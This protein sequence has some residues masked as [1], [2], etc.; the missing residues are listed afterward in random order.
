MNR[1]EEITSFLQFVY[2]FKLQ[3]PTDFSDN[4][5][6]S[7]LCSYGLYNEEYGQKYDNKYFSYW[8]EYYR[9][10]PNIDVYKHH[11]QP[12][13]LQF[14]N[15]KKFTDY[16]YVK[17]YINT[18]K[19]KYFNVVMKIF[20]YLSKHPEIE[21]LS[22]IADTCRS[23]Q[24]VLRIKEP[25]YAKEVID[26]INN[27][28]DIVNSL[29]Y[30]NP[31]L[32]RDGLVGIAFDNALSYNS[33]MANLIYN[34]V[35]LK[36]N[37][38]EISCSDFTNY[39]SLLHDD[40]IKPRSFNELSKLVNSD[41]FLKSYNR[42]LSENDPSLNIADVINNYLYVFDQ[43][44]KLINSDNNFS[45]YSSLYDFSR[46]P[47]NNNERK[48]LI[49]EKYNM[50]YY[51]QIIDSY[52]YYAYSKYNNSEE[53]SSRLSDYAKTKI[54]NPD[55]ALRYITRD[56]GYRS[57]FLKIESNTIYYITNND[58]YTYVENILGLTKNYD[59]GSRSSVS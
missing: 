4:I 6:Y 8:I 36:T 2:K 51:K 5:I 15:V 24:I 55:Y 39:V 42:M 23:D 32:M 45:Y 47:K 28:K 21:H 50:M 17:L 52:I 34:Y 12:S 33:T 3:Y 18:S 48:K 35:M 14:N 41:M 19:D 37:I 56:N 54:N 16:N 29:R 40:L 7:L 25:K 26:F 59:Y 27:E 10:N 57:K 53:V 46:S 9:N 43:F 38:N 20:N 13:F 31:F 44:P 30:T 49:I 11:L 22:K 1:K 58:V